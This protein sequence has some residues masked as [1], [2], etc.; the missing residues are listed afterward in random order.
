[1]TKPS[2]ISDLKSHPYADSDLIAW[3]ERLRLADDIYRTGNC[4]TLDSLFK[5]RA[6]SF[7]A[8][9][10]SSP[11]APC[12]QMSTLWTD[13]TYSVMVSNTSHNE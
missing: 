7:V 5:S 3:H 1:M 4:R 13:G 11:I 12:A 10:N 2:E 8:T 6:I 9:H